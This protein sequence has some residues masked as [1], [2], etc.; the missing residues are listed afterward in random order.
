MSVHSFEVESKSRRIPELDGVRGCAILFVIFY[1]YFEM[2]IGATTG[3]ALAFLK[4][5]LAFTFSGIDLFFVLSGFLIGGILFDTRT[6]AKYFQTFYIRRVSRI[7]PLYVVFCMLFALA[8]HFLPASRFEGLAGKSQIPWLHYAT[9]TQ[10]F[11]FARYAI[12]VPYW[13]SI[14]WSLAVEEQFYLITPF[15]IRYMKKVTVLLVVLIAGAPFFRL[16][17]FYYYKNDIAP[18]ALTICRVDALGLGVLA[19][20]MMRRQEVQDWLHENASSLSIVFWFLLAGVL[21]FTT[22]DPHHTGL[23]IITIGY[24]WIALFYVTVLLIAVTQH[25]NWLSRTLRVRPLMWIGSIAY[26]SYLF[27]QGINVICHALIL[28]ERPLLFDAPG[29]V[30]TLL[31]VVLTFILASLS[32]IYFEKPLISLGHRYTK[33][34]QKISLADRVSRS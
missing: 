8:N 16:L 32:W 13:L 2:R 9:F 15:V 17:A 12:W 20:I 19:A 25:D 21:F 1:H 18:Y 23:V 26:G 14:T 29:V 30:V 3:T 22:F 11:W 10:N 34:R 6:S 4:A 7:V 27:H 24:T 33:S 28:N 31:A 5:M